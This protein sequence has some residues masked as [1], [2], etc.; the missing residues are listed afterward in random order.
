MEPITFILIA[1][2]VV[3]S[4]VSKSAFAGAL[5][6]FAV[7]LLMLKLPAV[8]AI[9]L[10]LPI[11]IIGD[12]MSVKSFWRKWDSRLL[13]SLIP[14]AV[15][16]IVAANLLLEAINPDYIRF[17]IALI[18][19]VFSVKNLFF[20]QLKL[21]FLNHPVGAW[22]MSAA[23]GISSTLVHAG[24][25]PLIIYFTA[26]GLSQTR[27]VATAAAFF[28]VMNLI[29]LMG[30]LSLGLMTFDVALTALA[31]TPLAFVGNWLGLKIHTRIDKQQFM[32]IMNCL[33]LILGGW[34]IV[35]S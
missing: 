19:I 32:K 18:C 10:M 20:K 35:G 26:I 30:V 7:P 22:A 4:G 24:G 17:F 3:L 34:L 11:L 28:A 9:T 14:G 29:K 5:G 2:V 8:E 25:P 13:R 31:F 33:L 12:A 15:L 23:S 27:F 6:V 1:F 16:G 21:A